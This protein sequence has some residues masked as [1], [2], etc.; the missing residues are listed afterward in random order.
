MSRCWMV[1]KPL[2]WL[3]LNLLYF[4]GFVVTVEICKGPFLIGQL[5]ILALSD[6]DTFFRLAKVLKMLNCDE[7][8][9]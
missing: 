8:F 6:H 9:F 3:S 2:R 4:V 5:F 7:T 1:F